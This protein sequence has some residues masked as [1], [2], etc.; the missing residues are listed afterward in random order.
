MVSV[1]RPCS[2]S[3]IT[4]NIL[5]ARSRVGAIMVVSHAIG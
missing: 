1:G 3:P 2:S 4:S 5:G